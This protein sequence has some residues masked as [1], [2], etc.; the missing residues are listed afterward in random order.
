AGA[1][2]HGA[3][4]TAARTRAAKD[5]LSPGIATAYYIGMHCEIVMPGLPASPSLELLVARG[6]RIKAPARSVEQW[7]QHAFGIE[8]RLPAGA[9]SLY[10]AG[11]APGDAAWVRAD[12]VH[13]AV[14]RD[15]VLL[16]PALELTRAEA[17]SAC[18]A[19]NR[20]FAGTLEVKLIDPARWC[21]RLD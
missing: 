11:G 6:R 19:L 1:L 20:H 17:D 4:A 9:L 8:G 12:P 16:A 15:H 2:P 13:L 5:S 18:E 21:A 10:G 3:G 14:M 7:L